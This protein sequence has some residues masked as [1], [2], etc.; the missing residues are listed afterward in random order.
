VQDKKKNEKKI[1]RGKRNEGRLQVNWRDPTLTLFC[2]ALP[3]WG[4]FILAFEIFFRDFSLPLCF[5]GYPEQEKE[6]VFFPVHI[7]L[8]FGVLLAFWMCS[9]SPVVSF[10][11]YRIT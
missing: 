5:F 1:I 3:T 11:I 6:P 4:L 2:S 7:L 10:S 8:F 9:F